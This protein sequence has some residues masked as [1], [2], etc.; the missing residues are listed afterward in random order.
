MCVAVG[1]GGAWGTRARG[2]R[3]INA[4]VRRLSSTDRSNTVSVWWSR[5][6]RWLQPP[7]RR[8]SHRLRS[9]AARH[10]HPAEAPPTVVRRPPRQPRSQL[11]SV[12]AHSVPAISARPRFVRIVTGH[13]HR[14][15]HHHH[16]SGDDRLLP[17]GRGVLF[18][19]LCRGQ[20]R[21]PSRALSI[22]HASIRRRSS[23]T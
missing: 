16:L 18:S 20:K 9:A 23:L 13:R 5:R 11:R 8:R 12:R 21:L 1:A 17:Y 10:R 4:A 7:P 15:C 22:A 2:A 19:E 6:N 14:Q 3:A